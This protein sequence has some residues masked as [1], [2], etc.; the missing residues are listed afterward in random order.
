[1]TTTRTD[2][3]AALLDDLQE[4]GFLDEAWR[5]VF[6]AVPREAFIPELI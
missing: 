4:R 5:R 6:D 1:M 3:Y 2:G